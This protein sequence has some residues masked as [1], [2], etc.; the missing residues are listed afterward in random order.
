MATRSRRQDLE[1][2][3]LEASWIEIKSKG[4]RPFLLCNVYRPPE[5]CLEQWTHWFESVLRKVNVDRNEVII[6]GDVNID[7]SDNAKK[8]S[9]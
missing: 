5:V 1:V 2:E 7:L 4:S 9:M 6:M 8:T 3:D